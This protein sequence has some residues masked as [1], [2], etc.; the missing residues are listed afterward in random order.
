MAFL[1][2]LGVQARELELTAD[3]CAD[4]AHRRYAL[5]YDERRSFYSGVCSPAFKQ[6]S[7]FRQILADHLAKAKRAESKSRAMFKEV[8]VLRGYWLPRTIMGNSMASSPSATMRVHAPSTRSTSPLLSEIVEEEKSI[9]GPLGVLQQSRCS[10]NPSSDELAQQ[11][12]LVTAAPTQIQRDAAAKYW[13]TRAIGLGV[14][15]QFALRTM[16]RYVSGERDAEIEDLLRRQAI[17]AGEDSAYKQQ[18]RENETYRVL[19]EDTLRQ[20]AEQLKAAC[21]SKPRRLERRRDVPATK[22][23]E[24]V[25][26]HTSH[27]DNAELV[28]NLM[29]EIEMLKRKV[30]SLVRRDY[31]AVDDASQRGDHSSFEI[32]DTT[33]HDQAHAAQIPAEGEAGPSNWLSAESENSETDEWSLPSSGAA[34][35]MSSPHSKLGADAAEHGS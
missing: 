3:L 21:S 6:R 9:H 16:Q 7:I 10:L 15:K 29:Q 11:E 2:F 26:S 27:E 1:N 14:E 35:H 22:M 33:G 31:A 24:T 4:E 32:S 20:E 34:E 19:A 25:D 13:Y 23:D 17:E 12:R 8:R 5:A 18:R 30:T 28:R